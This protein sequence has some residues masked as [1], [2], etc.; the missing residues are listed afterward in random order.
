M[1]ETLCQNTHTNKQCLKRDSAVI[2][3]DLYLRSIQFECRSSHH[4]YNYSE[5][6]LPHYKVPSH[7]TA[8]LSIQKSC[9]HNMTVAS[10][11]LCVIISSSQNKKS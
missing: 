3:P 11:Y 6:V 10:T 7:Q 2:A 1:R 9:K 8:F 4:I 5:A